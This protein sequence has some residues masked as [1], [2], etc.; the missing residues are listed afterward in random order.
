MRMSTRG[1]Y[2]LR[3]M[4]DLALHDGEGPVLR[5][6]IAARQEISAE[7]VAQIF[8]RLCAAGLVKGI[9]GPGGGYQLARDSS[10]IRVGDI[11]RA[12]EGPIAA[13]RCV[14]ASP[15]GRSTCRRAEECTTRLVWVRLS[16]VIS[17]FLDDITLKDL[18]DQTRQPNPSRPFGHYDVDKALARS[19]GQPPHREASL[20]TGNAYT[21]EI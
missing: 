1:R 20:L 7:Y 2:A 19:V 8:Q 12:V 21:Y 3:A 16:Q 13:V 15:S 4:L 17:R 14:A 10:A 6:D 11:V 9:K 5:H 18:C